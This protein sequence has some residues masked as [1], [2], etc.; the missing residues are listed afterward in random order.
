MKRIAILMGVGCLVFSGCSKGDPRADNLA[1]QACEKK[2]EVGTSYN[3]LVEAAK[4]DE[5]Y[6]QYAE[7]FLVVDTTLVGT[8]NPA[9]QEA[10]AK[11]LVLCDRLK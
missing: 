8:N 9:Y 1:R 6:S 7:A 11:I 10:Q 3:L 4:L 5:S 2:A